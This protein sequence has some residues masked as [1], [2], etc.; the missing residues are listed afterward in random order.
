MLIFLITVFLLGYI[1]DPII[2]L[3]VDPFG[4]LSSLPTSSSSPFDEVHFVDGESSW[5]EHF[6]KGFASLGLLGFVKVF[7]SMSPWHW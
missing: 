1:A 7:F 6:V 4:T 2:N 3:Y 5:T